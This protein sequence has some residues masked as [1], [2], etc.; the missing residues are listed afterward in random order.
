[1]NIVDMHLTLGVCPLTLP[2]LAREPWTLPLGGNRL[3]LWKHPNQD[4]VSQGNQLSITKKKKE[5]F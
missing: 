4:N 5:Y 3:Y 2:A 1:M